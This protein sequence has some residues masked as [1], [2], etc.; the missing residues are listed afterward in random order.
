[1]NSRRMSTKRLLFFGMMVMCGGCACRSQSP[2]IDI[3]PVS[4]DVYYDLHSFEQLTDEEAF[5][6]LAGAT[7]FVLGER[8]LPGPQMV[9]QDPVSV[10]VH[11][12]RKLL[13]HDDKTAAFS[14][15]VYQGTPAGICYGL[16]G[17][18]LVNRQRAAELA[19]PWAQSGVLI[20]VVHGRRRGMST[21][22]LLIGDPYDPELTILGGGIPIVLRDGMQEPFDVWVHTLEHSCDWTSVR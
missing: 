8:V 15:L 1:M 11:C 16:S 13:H 17:L 4:R 9:D 6:V 10:E 7:E 3:Q 18:M 14:R 21:L 20:P 2:W 19:K 5:A 12:F 22:R